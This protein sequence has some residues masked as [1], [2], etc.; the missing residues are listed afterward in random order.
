MPTE[1]KCMEVNG[2]LVT[3]TEAS[4]LSVLRSID[5][6]NENKLNVSVT[7]LRLEITVGTSPMKKNK[8]SYI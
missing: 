7:K 4:D 8:K 2:Q 1:M 3:V 6:S 5:L